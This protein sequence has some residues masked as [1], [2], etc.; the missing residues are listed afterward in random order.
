[1][2]RWAGKRPKN[3]APRVEGRFM[4]GRSIDEIR[5]ELERLNAGTA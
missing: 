2:I 4:D 5:N 3:T 1:M